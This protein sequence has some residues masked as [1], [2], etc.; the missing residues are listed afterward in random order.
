MKKDNVGAWI[1][2]FVKG[3]FIGSSFILP[4]ISGSVIAAVF[5]VYERMIKFLAD[6]RKDFRANFLFFLPIAIGGIIGVFAISAFLSV[7][8]DVAR[9]QLIWFFIGCIVGTLPQLW[10]KAGKL[11]R[12]KVHFAVLAISAIFAFAFL[13]F[14]ERA[15]IGEFPLNF[16]T[17]TFAGGL[18]GLVAIVPGFSA[19]TLLYFFGI[20]EPMADGIAAFDI[21]VILPL[22]IGGLIAIVAFSK[23]MAFV[24]RKAYSGL[25]HAIIGFVIASTVVI[26]PLDFN[27]V[28]IGGLICA[29]AAIAGAVVSRL[30]C[31]LE[32][33]D[34]VGNA[35]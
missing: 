20:L 17:W 10:R 32:R 30:L 5:G 28:S 13:V 18:I 15:M 1:I 34:D 25:Y 14:I 2:R 12:K 31:K 22:I 27:Y 11:G 16:G 21:G 19:S 3:F 24:L 26:I 35:R 33:A 23:L 7:A 9:A 4:G 6:I 29:V 8:L